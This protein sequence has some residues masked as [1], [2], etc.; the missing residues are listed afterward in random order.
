MEVILPYLRN[1]EVWIYSL[2]GL[3][4]VVYLKKLIDAWRDWQGT[5]FGLEREVAQ[6]RFSTALTILFLLVAFILLEF[7]TVSF[8]APSYPQNISLPTATLDLLATPTITIVAQVNSA[9]TLV[10]QEATSSATVQPATV[11]RVYSRAD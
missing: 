2:L 6:R 8:I 9:T 11:R 10:V 3:I 5:V 1:Y 7:L 4:A